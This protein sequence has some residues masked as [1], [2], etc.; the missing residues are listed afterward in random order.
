MLVLTRRINESII[1]NGNI[2]VTLLAVEGDKVKLGISAPREVSIYRQELAEGIAAQEKLQAKLAEA[3][4][5]PDTFS[6]LRD[7]LLSQP[8][9]EEPPAENKDA[10]KPAE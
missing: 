7:L 9:E 8:P 5:V 2:T 6:A 4:K 1:I 10:D 3:G